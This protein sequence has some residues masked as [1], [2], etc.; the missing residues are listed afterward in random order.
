MTEGLACHA[1]EI[2]LHSV[3][4]IEPLVVIKQEN[5]MRFPQASDTHTM[6]LSQA[7]NSTV[8][9]TACAN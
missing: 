1:K 2:L 4:E 9:A 8:P 5:D 6:K 3:V 7:I